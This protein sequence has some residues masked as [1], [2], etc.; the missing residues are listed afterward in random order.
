M[1]FISARDSVRDIYVVYDPVLY[2]DTDRVKRVF[3]LRELHVS[4]RV[5]APRRRREM[6]EH[7]E[8]IKA[9][10]DVEVE[11]RRQK[12]QAA[13]DEA[14]A[15]RER[16]MEEAVKGMEEAV[17]KMQE[18]LNVSEAE[19]ER[20]QDELDLMKSRASAK[21]ELD[22]AAI[23][24]ARDE[25]E[26]ANTCVSDLEACIES[27]N[28]WAMRARVHAQMT[29]GWTEEE[30]ERVFEGFSVASAK[31]SE[32]TLDAEARGVGGGAAAAAQRRLEDELESATRPETADERATELLRQLR[33]GQ[34]READEW[35]KKFDDVGVDVGRG[36]GAEAGIPAVAEGAGGLLGLGV[37]GF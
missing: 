5:G 21:A 3:N 28:A 2:I 9:S 23:I 24:A 6:A 19:K 14:M 29:K 25:A 30:V 12:L 27:M 37:F 34:K 26:K 33:A 11:Q 1:T 8:A 31:A 18:L 7:E 17:N 35:K 32:V 20:V 16:G 4:E 22:I 13:M 36:D 15:E 10:C